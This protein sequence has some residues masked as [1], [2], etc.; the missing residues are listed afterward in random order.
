[1]LNGL[2]NGAKAKRVKA[3]ANYTCFG[4]TVKLVEVKNFDK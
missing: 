1:M 2:T 3:I 4:I